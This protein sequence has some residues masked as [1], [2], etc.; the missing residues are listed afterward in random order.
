MMTLNDIRYNPATL[1]SLSAVGLAL[2]SSRTQNMLLRI[3]SAVR[4]THHQQ[5]KGVHVY[6]YIERESGQL[7]S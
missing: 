1:T 3:E 5:V 2:K 7:Q 4:Y 6:Y